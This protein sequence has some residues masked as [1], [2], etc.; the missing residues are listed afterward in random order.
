[1][2]QSLQMTNAATRPANNGLE[3]AADFVGASAGEIAPYTI[4]AAYGGAEYLL[5]KVGLNAIK[6]PL[7]K[8][9]CADSAQG[10]SLE[11]KSK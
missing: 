9:W 6:N 1:A 11:Q 10:P 4:G 7:V 8:T 2:T 3:K 5:G